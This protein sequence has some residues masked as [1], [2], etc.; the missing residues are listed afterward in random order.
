MY[1]TS[2][3]CICMEV[4]SDRYQEDCS[5]GDG[6]LQQLFQHMTKLGMSHPLGFT[7]NNDEDHNICI[8]DKEM[9]FRGCQVLEIK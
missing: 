4:C 1:L 5:P 9:L 6:C 3:T 2:R 8:F 7:P